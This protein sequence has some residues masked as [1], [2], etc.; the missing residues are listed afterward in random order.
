MTKMLD[1]VEGMKLPLDILMQPIFLGGN[2]GGGKTHGAKKLFEAGHD[3]GAQCISIAPVGKWWSLRLGKDGKSAGLKDVFVFGGT[4]GDVP[5]TPE[6]GRVI[7]KILVEKRIHAVIDVSL[8]RKGERSRFLADFLEEFWLLKKLEDESYPVVLFFEEAHA[9]V[10]Q[11]PGPEQLRMLGA[12]EDLVREGRNH[13]VGVVLIDQRSAVVNKNVIALV[14]VIIVLRTIHH[15]DRDTYELWCTDKGDDVTWLKEVKGLQ[16]GEAFIYAPGLS[17][18]V[19]RVK[20]LKIRTFDATKTASIGDKIAKVGTLS[21]VDISGLKDD[22]AAIVVEAEK[23]NPI[24]LKK[25]IAELE[26]DLKAEKGDS[27]KAVEIGLR[28]HGSLAAEKTKVQQEKVV[29][30]ADITRLLKSLETLVLVEVKFDT[31]TKAVRAQME[32]LV[33]SISKA[34]TVET[35]RTVMVPTPRGPVKVKMVEPKYET[36][37]ETIPQRVPVAIKD[38]DSTKLK[39]GARKMLAALWQFDPKPLTRPQLGSLVGLPHDKSTFGSYLSNLFLGGFITKVGDDVALLDVGRD[40]VSN[41]SPPPPLTHGTLMQIWRPRFKS[42]AR[43]MLDHL[44]QQYPMKVSRED[45][46]NFLGL[47]H[48]KSTFG[49]YLSN[50]SSSGLVEK[51]GKDFLSASPTLFPERT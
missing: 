26:K 19:T 14:E 3:A 49:S 7:A 29:L 37:Y 42:G 11:K 51:E 32:R 48:D 28:A 24:V 9:I 44:V 16:A 38:V 30:K 23:N 15:L 2:R 22:L 4:H 33:E 6:S 20:I 46:G 17:I 34:R 35:A 10:P 43:A 50:L 13:G 21:K 12:A 18:P 47:P 41:G 31:S 8:M 27:K 25:R 5:L 1:F 39:A 40:L 36:T 45:L